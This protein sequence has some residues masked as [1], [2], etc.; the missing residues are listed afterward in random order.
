VDLSG[1]DLAHEFALRPYPLTAGRRLRPDDQYAC[2]LEDGFARQAGVGPGDYLLVWDPSGTRPIPFEIVGLFERHRVAQFQ[3]PL[4]LMRLEMLQRATKKYALVSTIDVTLK[5]ADRKAM[6]VAAAQIRRLVKQTAG[7]ARVRSAEARLKQVE[8]AQSN[9]RFVLVLLGCVAMLT[10]LFIIL[11]TLSMGLLERVRQLGLLR[12]VGMTRLQLM[13]LVLAEVLPLGALGVGLGVPLGLGLTALTVWIVPQ[14]VGSLIVSRS[15]IAQAIAAGLVTTLIAA[16]LPAVAVSGVSPLEASRPRARRPRL[17]LLYVVGLAALGLLAWQHYGL[18]AHTQRDVTFVSMAAAAIVVLYAGYALLAAPVVRIIGTP[19]VALAA[20]LLH[21]RHRLLQDQVGYAVWR[22]AGICCGL[23][24]GLSLIV[25]IVVVNNSVS[26]GWQ[27]PKQFP[28]AFIW[29]FET[30]PP[31]ARTQIIKT[32]GVGDFTLISSINVIVEERRIDE[33]FLRA[34]TWFMAVDPDSFFDLVKLEFLDGEGDE[35]S[36]REKL[37]RGG[38][39]IIADDFARSRNKHIGDQVKIWDDHAGRWRFFKIAGV[40]RSPALDIAASYFQMLSEYSV[41]ASGSVMGTLRDA[42][43]KFGVRRYNLALLNFDL[44]PAPPP[45][46]WPPSRNTPEGRKLPARFYDTSI[47]LARRWQ[48]WREAQVLA[49]LRANLRDPGVRVGSVGDLKDEIDS[50][51]SA[52]TRLLAAIPAVALLV[53][54]I[55]VA[56]LMTANV[57]ARA[58]QLAILRAIGATRGLVLRMVIGEALVLGLLG[59]ALGLAL[60]FHLAGDITD[61]VARMWG[62]KVALTLPWVYV[63]WTVALTMGLCV[64]AGVLPAR[65]ASRTNIVDALHVT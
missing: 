23:M 52:V 9:Q 14:Y 3:K 37:R 1:V 40:V 28:A 29:T 47:P 16:L 53:A 63:L 35:R 13:G 39:V 7:S 59:N 4:A 11:S 50:Q 36:A 17:F 27:F 41:A 33:R 49:A 55:G 6:L 38:Y 24:V 58:R 31:N 26:R 25:A 30:L 15:G 56:N 32:P 5:R 65:H 19:A 60:G 57:H 12:C 62:Y 18:I 46:G 42:R 43:E 8:M 45:P 64:L 10:A 51:L 34:Y 48:R 54:A 61:L 44:P 2:M 22:S 21:V 20:R